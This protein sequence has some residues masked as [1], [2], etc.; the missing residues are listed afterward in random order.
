MSGQQKKPE[1]P[2]LS[3]IEA[4]KI[5]FSD[6]S[7]TLEIAQGQFRDAKANLVRLL[8]TQQVP[9]AQPAPEAPKDPKA[10]GDQGPVDPAKPEGGDNAGKKEETQEKKD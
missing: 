5:R 8:R 6:A 3:P 4:A 1:P 7:I 10:E 9:P 2:R